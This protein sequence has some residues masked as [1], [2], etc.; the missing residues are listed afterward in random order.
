LRVKH[1]VLQAA[2]LDIWFDGILKAK[3]IITGSVSLIGAAAQDSL[4]SALLIG[5]QTGITL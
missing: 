2:M 5:N 4:S 1:M 3:D